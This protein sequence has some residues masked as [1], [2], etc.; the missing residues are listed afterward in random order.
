MVYENS[1]VS[2]IVPVYNKK[3]NL[4]MCIESIIGQRHKNLEII[5]VDDGST[6]GSS[7]ICDNFANRDDRIRVIHIPNS[8]ASNARNTGIRISSGA[9]LQF[10]DADDFISPEMTSTLYEA[11]QRDQSGMAF[12]GYYQLVDGK[13]VRTIHPYQDAV[14]SVE[15]YFE[16]IDVFHLDPLCGSPWN[17]LYDANIIRGNNILYKSGVNFAEDFSFNLEVLKHIES[18]SSVDQILYYYNVDVPSSLSKTAG[19]KIESSW[20]QKKQFVIFL[21]EVMNTLILKQELM[22][23]P[24]TIYFELL[25]ISLRQRMKQKGGG[26]PDEICDWLKINLSPDFDFHLDQI[27]LKNKQKFQETC[28]LR[29]RLKRC[30]VKCYRKLLLFS[31]KHNISELFVKIMCKVLRS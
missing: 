3:A 6:D 20:D 28:S 22:H 11:I 30:F 15:D 24:S 19:K 21:N 4:E 26:S 27:S 18:I 16:L 12:C 17:R 9:Y 29:R 1:L 31:I 10:A 13:T 2:V 8:G 25:D 7:E 14:I 5:I 23:I